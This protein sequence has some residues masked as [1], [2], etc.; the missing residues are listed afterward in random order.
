MATTLAI[1]IKN[2]NGGA[3]EHIISGNA[4]V[5]TKSGNAG[6]TIFINNRNRALYDHNG[7]NFSELPE[8]QNNAFGANLFFQPTENQK[9]EASFSSLREY[10]YGGEMVDTPA[11]L[12][13]QSEERGHDVLTGN[14]DYQLNFNNDNSSIIAFLAGQRT[15]RE[16]YTGIFPDD[17]LDIIQHLAMPPYGTSLNTTLQGGTQ[18]NHRLQHFLGGSNV[19]TVGAEYVADD[20][21]DTIEAYNY[22]VDQLTKNLGVFLQSDWEATS[23]LNLLAG[24]RADQHNLVGNPIFSP[25]VSLLYKLKKQCTSAPLLGHRL[26]GTSG[27]RC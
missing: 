10:R 19:I 16:H 1:P 5:L 13:R 24:I 4:T 25:R 27:I 11:H 8:L 21:L 15:S 26:P 18:I 2:I 23:R 7:D 3:D 14:L 12:A 22:Q 20:V 17:S 6:A 9:L